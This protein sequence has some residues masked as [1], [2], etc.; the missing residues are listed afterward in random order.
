MP[1]AVIAASASGDTTILSGVTGKRFHIRSLFLIAK[2][3]VDIK[4][5]SGSTDIT[6]V[7]GLIAGEAIL[8]EEQ[9]SGPW[10]SGLGTNQAFVINLSGIFTVGG[11]C[12]YDLLEG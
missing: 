1:N 10:L 3:A 11:M 6:G 5:K 8:L 7:M 2:S 9:K 12:I 4:F